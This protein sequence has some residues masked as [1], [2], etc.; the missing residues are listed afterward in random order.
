MKIQ[1]FKNGWVTFAEAGCELNMV[2][3][4]I[5]LGYYDKKATKYKN[6]IYDEINKSKNFIEISKK[7]YNKIFTNKVFTK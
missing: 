5:Y 7:S 2:E 1:V 4:N 6:W 3:H